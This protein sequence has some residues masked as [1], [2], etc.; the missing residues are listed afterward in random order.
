MKYDSKEMLETA[1]LKFNNGEYGIAESILQQLVLSDASNPEVFHL[2]GCISY[3]KGKIKKAVKAFRRALDIN[4]DYTDSTVGLS[5]VLN[6][7]GRYEEAKRVFNKGLTAERKTVKA[8]SN[9]MI[10][11]K[12]ALKHREL[13][14]L[15]MQIERF[16][17]ASEQYIEAY[18]IAQNEDKL[19]IRMQLVNCYLKKNETQRAINELKRIIIE[20]PKFLEA[21]IKL[22]EA[23]YGMNRT[24][25]A[26]EQWESVLLRDPDNQRVLKL[27]SQAQ[28]HGTTV[29]Y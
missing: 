23:L 7:T 1:R 22:G 27:I 5:M 19:L 29:L 18:K 6:D 20:R 17:E 15:Y 28:R 3:K 8:R 21:K 2:I 13:G 16:D 24:M 12:I 11:D 25:D 14:D 10:E 26:V 9:P 4:P